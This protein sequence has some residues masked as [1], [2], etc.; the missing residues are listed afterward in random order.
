[1]G[2]AC[3]NVKTKVVVGDTSVVPAK[4]TPMSKLDECLTIVIEF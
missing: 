1:M 2:K 4:H 3:K